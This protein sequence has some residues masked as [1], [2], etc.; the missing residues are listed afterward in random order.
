MKTIV[1]SQDLLAFLFDDRIVDSISTIWNIATVILTVVA[2]RR[3]MQNTFLHMIEA[4][5]VQILKSSTAKTR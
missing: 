3:L 5:S 1:P 4:I 2:T